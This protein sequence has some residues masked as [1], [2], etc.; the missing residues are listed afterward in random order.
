MHREGSAQPAEN[1]SFSVRAGCC[2]P[3]GGVRHRLGI[4]SAERAAGRL[5]AN[6]RRQ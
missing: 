3:Q 5:P 6:S 1:A 2:R 4:P